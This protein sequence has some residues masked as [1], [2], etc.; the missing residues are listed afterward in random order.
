MQH[1][2]YIKKGITFVSLST[3]KGSLAKKALK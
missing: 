1:I 3:V 2:A